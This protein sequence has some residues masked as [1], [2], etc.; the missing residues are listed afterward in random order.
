M[1]I[2]S[3][4]VSQQ[5]E[6]SRPKPGEPFNPWRG[7]CGFYPPDVVGRQKDLTSGQKRLYERLVRFAGRNGECYPSH[8]TLAEALGITDRQ[9]RRI[10]T[11]L[12]KYPLIAHRLRDGRRANTYI[13][14]WNPIF[15]R[16]SKSGQAQDAA[17]SERTSTSAQA[18]AGVSGKPGLSG[19]FGSLSGHPRPEN[20]ERKTNT[21]VSRADGVRCVTSMAERDAEAPARSDSP[22][23]VWPSHMAV[24]REALR[25]HA[26]AIGREQELERDVDLARRLEEAAGGNPR[27][28][29]AKIS[30]ISLRRFGPVAV[31]RRPWPRTLAYWVTAIRTDRD[32]IPRIAPQWATEATEGGSGT[33]T[34][35]TAGP[36]EPGRAC[37]PGTAPPQSPCGVSR[38]VEGYH[39]VGPDDVAAIRK[40]LGA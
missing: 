7:A 23:H 10:L 19:H 36:M 40:A 13:F 30:K 9:V 12:E 5:G 20:S 15:D 4:S 16:T 3:H 26:R 18:P 28:A 32:S 33:H 37:A 1:T 11:A 21:A 22:S 24:V 38:R 6:K 27:G 39:R 34:L 8:D 2:D 25:E 17:Q 31:P 35:T 29:A 14:V